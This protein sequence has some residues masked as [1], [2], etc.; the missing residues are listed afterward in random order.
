MS[1]N[2]VN[3]AP[4]GREVNRRRGLTRSNVVKIDLLTQIELL[5]RKVWS[6]K[7]YRPPIWSGSR[8]SW[9]G[10]SVARDEDQSCYIEGVAGETGLKC[11]ALDWELIERRSRES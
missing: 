7:R 6:E 10:E 1:K 8:Q 9:K 11:W 3:A 4:L 5:R 2:R